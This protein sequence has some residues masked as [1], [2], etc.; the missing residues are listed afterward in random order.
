MLPTL[1]ISHGAPLLA[2]QPGAS[3]AALQRLAAELPEPRAILVLSAHWQSSTLTIGSAAQPRTWHDFHGFPAPL[4]RLDYPAPGD[5][6][7]ARQVAERLRQAGIDCAEDPQRPRDHGAWVPLLLMYPQ[8]RIPVVELSLPESFTPAQLMA[9]GR[10]LRP[11]RE[12]GVLLIGSGSLT[13]NLGELDWQARD[14]QAADWARDFRDWLL[15]RLDARDEQ[16]LADYRRQAP[17]AMRNHPTD[18][19]LLPLF[20][21]YGA[22]ER[23]GLVHQGFEYGSLSMD[24]LR[25][26]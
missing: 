11:L 26:D 8:A 22:G 17:Q 3:G 24:I 21:A 12:Q 23:L 20:F 6:A 13:H 5:P 10:A 1:F 9:L 14:G 15:A 7:L 25:F 18:E 19:H 4:Y 2:L 16:A